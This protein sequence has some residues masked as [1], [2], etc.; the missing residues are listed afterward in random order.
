MAQRRGWTP[1]PLENALASRRPPPSGAAPSAGCGRNP[2][3]RIVVVALDADHRQDHDRAGPVEQTGAGLPPRHSPFVRE[4]D[5]RAHD[6][7]RGETTE[8]AISSSPP[9]PVRPGLVS[10]AQG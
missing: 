1:T 5:H 2:V 6:A 3:D 8:P 7:L 9:G 10:G 4:S